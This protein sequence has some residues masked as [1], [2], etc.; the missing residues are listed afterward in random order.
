MKRIQMGNL[1]K[2]LV[3]LSIVN[4]GVYAENRFTSESSEEFS[5]SASLDEEKDTPEDGSPRNTLRL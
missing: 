5:I 4:S 2:S 3:L 1:I